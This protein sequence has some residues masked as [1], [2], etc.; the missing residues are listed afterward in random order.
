MRLSARLIGAAFL[1]LLA[2]SLCAGCSPSKWGPTYP[3][4][5]IKE[6]IIKICKTEYNIDVKVRVV[7]KTVAIY[8]PLE[9][10]MDFTFAL[11][12]S[13][14][15]KINDVILSVSRVVLSTDAKL[16]YYCLI[17]HDVRIPEI[18]VI[19]IKSVD[20]VKRLLLNDISRGEYGK[21]ILI[22]VRLNPQS[23]KERSVKDVFHR[24]GLDPKW[25]E[26]VMNDFFRAEPTMLGDIGYWNGRFYVKDITKP[27]FMAEQMASRVKID[28][29]ENKELAKD[30]QLKLAKGSYLSKGEQHYFKIEVLAEPKWLPGA[31][32]AGNE[33]AV[34]P[35]LVAIAAQVVHIYRFDDFDFVEIVSQY[36]NRVLTVSKGMLEDYRKKKLK[37]EEISG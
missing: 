19:I 22:D 20:D 6:S 33:D 34:L 18:Q 16:D 36:D 29:R 5:K 14:S 3:K 2:V 25:Q 30:F 13:A 12:K 26:T 17:A 21:R 37:F 28:F 10:L 31:A 24:M 27:E 23:Q 7:G 9:D 8:I 32:G 15:E 4:E 11:T 1:C 35:S